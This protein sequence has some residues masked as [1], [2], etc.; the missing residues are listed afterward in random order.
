MAANAVVIV[1]VVAVVTGS[2]AAAAV[3]AVVV[4]VIVIPSVAVSVAVD[5]ENGNNS[6]NNA[7]T[8]NGTANSIDIQSPLFYT[9]LAFRSVAFK[10]ACAGVCVCVCVWVH[11]GKNV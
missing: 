9:A 10:C 11:S 6:I 5:C 1:V 2:A 7:T 8:H 4:V 3:A